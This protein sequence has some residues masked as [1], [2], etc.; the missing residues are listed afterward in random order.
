MNRW[1]ESL[2]KY[3]ASIG[4]ATY[5]KFA[6]FSFANI[7]FLK[8]R[9]EIFRQ[10]FAFRSSVKKNNRVRKISDEKFSS[11]VS[12]TKIFS[13]TKKRQFTV[14]CLITCIHYG[15]KH[16]IGYTLWDM[17]KWYIFISCLCLTRF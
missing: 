12:M 14:M 8:F 4:I 16:F 15:N 3:N 17:Y 1:K 10:Y 9:C 6:N 13:M 7:S 5:R 2:V 11:R